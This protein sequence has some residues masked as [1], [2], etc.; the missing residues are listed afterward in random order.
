MHIQVHSILRLE[1]MQHFSLNYAHRISY[2]HRKKRRN[3]PSPSHNKTTDSTCHSNLHQEKNLKRYKSFLSTLDTFQQALEAV[4][5]ID[6][7]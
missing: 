6:L 2:A 3:V 4:G 5:T 7:I 1:P